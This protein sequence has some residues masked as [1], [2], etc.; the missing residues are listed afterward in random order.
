M[1]AFFLLTLGLALILLSVNL[2][3]VHFHCKLQHSLTTLCAGENLRVHT[4]QS[5]ARAV[6]VDSD[7]KVRQ[8]CRYRQINLALLLLLLL[9]LLFLFAPLLSSLLLGV[10]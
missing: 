8:L 9:L 7:F 4:I 2:V 3:A 5:I 6:V 10:Y 1:F